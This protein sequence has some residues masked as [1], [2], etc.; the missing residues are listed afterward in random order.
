MKNGS[1]TKTYSVIAALMLL[2]SC[3][4]KVNPSLQESNSTITPPSPTVE[5]QYFRLVNNSDTLLGYHLHKTGSGNYN[6]NCEVK[7]TTFSTAAYAGAASTYDITC[8]FEAE[9]LALFFNG[10]DWSV[11]SS[12][13]TCE[14]IGYTPFSFHQWQPGNSTR[15]VTYNECGTGVASPTTT[16]ACGRYYQQSP[17]VTIPS[18]NIATPIDDTI[19][20]EGELCRFNYTSQ[21]GPNCDEGTITITKYNWTHTDDPAPSGTDTFTQS[22]SRVS[23]GGRAANCINGAIKDVASLEGLSIGT[24]IIK[25]EYNKNFSRKYTIT[26]PNTKKF[27]TNMYAANYMRQ[28]SGA[29]YNNDTYNYAGLP[30]L[31]FNPSQTTINMS[32]FDLLSKNY[33]RDYNHANLGTALFDYSD[34]DVVNPGRY[35]AQN[36]KV[37]ALANSPH[38]AQRVQGKWTSPYYNF[39]CLNKAQDVKARIRV[40][41]RDWDRAFT[42]DPI[43]EVMSDV[44]NGMDALMDNNYDELG[45]LDYYDVFNDK[46]D[47]DDFLLFQTP[48]NDVVPSNDI[49]ACERPYPHTL[50]PFSR[51]SFPQGEL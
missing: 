51:G 6:K 7:A 20:N 35:L 27:K 23:C 47:W 19:A 10:L 46:P 9:E 25:T 31:G 1:K 5:E 17:S 41:I 34:P 37:R 26:A 14:Y 11:E 48:V 3:N 22:V 40:M 8:F 12:A 38:S 21:G 33:K 13:N 43:M 49:P 29:D 44:Y 18:P 16:G 30:I 15:T 32:P 2:A 39:Y 50:E 45:N 4:E 36:E 28:C 42:V 24:E